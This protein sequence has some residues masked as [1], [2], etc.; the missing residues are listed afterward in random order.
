M[1]RLVV[2]LGINCTIGYGTLLYSF[3]LLALEIEKEFLWS[4]EFIYG[5][6]S[7]GLLLGGVL[8][9]FL[10]KALDRWGVRIPMSL[11]SLLMALCLIGLSMMDGRISFMFFLLLLEAL[12]MLVLYEAAFVALAHVAG[13][14][15]R[16]PITHI[17]LMAGFASTIFWPFIS[18]LLTWMNWREVYLVFALLHLAV[19][20]PLHAFVLQRGRPQNKHVGVST[21]ADKSRPT[22]RWKAEI[23]LSL[24]V[25]LVAFCVNGLQIHLFSLLA[26]LQVSHV[27]AVFAGALIGPFQV[28]SRIADMLLVK[29]INVVLLG[30]LSSLSMLVG[31]L[32]LLITPWGSAYS[33]LVF[34]AF[35]GLGQGLTYIVRGAIP[36]YLFG[37][38]NY[39]SITGRINGVRM[40]MTAISPISFSLGM[41]YMGVPQTLVL[42]C[43]CLFVSAIL[44]YVLQ[45]PS[46]EL[47]T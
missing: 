40:I 45:A 14:S 22:I 39:G 9:P 29:K 5:V 11:G 15:A 19:C 4:S 6:Y 18:W 27:I 42:V 46:R 43:V 47:V 24:S 34:A 26:S 12:S 33:I 16:L 35:F 38:K 28:V 44:L 13:Q 1:K 8:A 2:A 20:L 30:V 37:E 25:G 23:I 3:S 41:E 7:L 31:I 21:D 17:T 36:L 10:G 32:L